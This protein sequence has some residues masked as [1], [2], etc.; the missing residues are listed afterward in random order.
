ME[1]GGG[2]KR[3]RGRLGSS[4]MFGGGPSGEGNGGAIKRQK[5]GWG[6]C[7]RTSSDWNAKGEARRGPGALIK[8]KG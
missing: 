5:K 1:P 2:K 8:T 6:T 4:V 7:V 3:G